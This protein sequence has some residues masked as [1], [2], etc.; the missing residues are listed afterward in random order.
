MIPA[1]IRRP[2]LVDGSLSRLMDVLTGGAFLAGLGLLAGA[3]N[4][5]F[6][7]LASL[8]F[9]AQVLQIP[10]VALLLRWKNRRSDS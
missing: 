4:L 1:E 3:S 9:L 10:T 2:L 7:L 5:Q 8:P 6:A